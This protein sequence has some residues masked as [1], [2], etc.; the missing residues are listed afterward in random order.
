[1]ATNHLL[2]FA[3]ATGANVMDSVSYQA[4]NAR[5]TGFVNGV[6]LPEQANTAWRQACFG[7]AMIGQFTA[8]WS[9]QDVNDDGNVAVFETNFRS[10]VLSAVA[11]KTFFYGRDSGTADALAI[12][13]SPAAT[14]YTDG[15]VVAVLKGNSVNGTST[16]Q[17]NVSNLGARTIVKANGSALSAGDLVANVEFI[18]VYDGTVGVFRI[19]HL[20][21]SDINFLISQQTALRVTSNQ[22]LYVNASTGSD[23][24]KGTVGAPFLTLQA[25]RNYAQNN[26]NLNGTYSVTYV[27]TGAFTAGVVA[28]G[29]IPGQNGPANE[30]FSFTSGSSVA[31][32]DANCLAAI[33]GAQFTV[34]ALS[35]SVL[36]TTSGSA[37]GLG[38][39]IGAFY[40]GSQ[41][42]VGAGLNFGTAYASHV[43]ANG[44]IINL[45]EAYTIS[46]SAQSHLNILGAGGYISS[47]QSAPQT[48]T[49][50]GT[51][52]F[53]IA[54][55]YTR[56]GKIDHGGLTFI[57]SATGKRYDVDECSG[58]ST[59]G[60]GANYL[61]GSI[62]GT[63]GTAFGYYK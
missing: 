42:R 50:V 34:Q 27:A 45:N 37:N 51:P 18:A 30:V 35:G 15:M 29:L 24:N 48:I 41:V 43:S 12:L 7:A 40:G 9:G 49:L 32:T 5:L 44:G 56:A 55:A 47:N 21:T 46:G 25:V 19:P 2:P 59:N 39:A 4:L 58:I 62:A 31:V 16:P 28:N 3:T 13:P 60:G 6:A 26:F 10:A 17:L 14:G 11:T 20:L 53:S 52:N 63:G 33:N 57:G 54:Y 38:F 1:M 22:T 36:L 8:D 61:P 23:S